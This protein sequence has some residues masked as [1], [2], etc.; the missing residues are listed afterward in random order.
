M[1]PKTSVIYPT[2]FLKKEAADLIAEY[3]LCKGV[4]VAPLYVLLSLFFIC[5]C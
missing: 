5:S 3:V 1:S 4:F 2:P